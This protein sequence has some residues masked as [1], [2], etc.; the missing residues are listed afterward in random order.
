V[1]SKRVG[2]IDA[3]AVLTR[4]V[5]HQE[6]MCDISSENS[7]LYV[8]VNQFSLMSGSLLLYLGFFMKTRPPLCNDESSLSRSGFGLKKTSLSHQHTGNVS[9]S[10]EAG[11]SSTAE[12]VGHPRH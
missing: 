5:T 1:G 2:E 6:P 3:S 12:E 8:H 9:R 11:R 7:P 10:K 4:I